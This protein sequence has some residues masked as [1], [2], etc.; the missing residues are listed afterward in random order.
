MPIR[1]IIFDFDGT[2]ADTNSLKR[3]PYFTLLA[4]EG[5]V[6]E[7]FDRIHDT[8]RSRSRYEIFPDLL[9]FLRRTEE[10]HPRHPVVLDLAAKYNE[11][12]EQAVMRSEATPG[13]VE[14]LEA[15]HRKLPLYLSTLTPEPAILKVLEARQWTR[16]FRRIFGYPRDKTD[17]VREVLALE[18]L[19]AEEILVVGDGLS[20]QVSAEKNGVRF[21]EVH[22]STGLAPLLHL[23]QD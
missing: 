14:F 4:G 23:L 8:D 6:A 3:A 13:A 11:L 16:Y 19:R 2:L 18:R 1:S 7:D 22:A 9:N 20:D 10:Y 21:L 12:V 5:L 17:T 15:Y